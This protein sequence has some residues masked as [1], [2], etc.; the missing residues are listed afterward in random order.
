V[1]AQLRGNVESGRWGAEQTT[2]T[3]IKGN[4]VIYSLSSCLTYKEGFFLLS[5][6][7]FT[8]PLELQENLHIGE[9]FLHSLFIYTFLRSFA[10]SLLYLSLVSKRRSL[11]IFWNYVQS[12][13]QP[14]W[15]PSTHKSSNPTT[16]GSP[17]P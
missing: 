15:H 3:D 2:S 8:R 6:Y 7:I 4:S 13:F 5:E 10:S 1:S 14:K 9:L 12:S 17:P 11:R 16:P